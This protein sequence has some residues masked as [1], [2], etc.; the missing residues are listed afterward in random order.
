MAN[1]SFQILHRQLHV[2]RSSFACALLTLLALTLASA[3]R[4]EAACSNEAIREAQTSEVLPNGTTYLPSCMALE[5]LNPPKK[6]GQETS[7][8]GAFSADGSRALFVS[9]AALAETPGLQVFVGDNYVATRDPAGWATDPTSPPAPAAILWG[10]GLNGGPFAFGEDLDRWVMQGATQA[11][12]LAGESQFFT[13]APGGVFKALSP[14]LVPVDQSGESQQFSLNENRSSGSSAD[15]SAT[16]FNSKWSSTTYLSGDPSTTSIS[17]EGGYTPSYLVHRDALGQPSI[18]LLARDKDGVVY[19]GRCGSRLGGGSGLVAGAISPDASRIYFSTRPAQAFDSN[20]AEGPPCTTTNPL[21]ILKRS[22]TPSG[23]EITEL[24]PG[25]PS[26]AGDDIFQGASLDGTKAYLTSPRKLSADDLDTSADPCS[27]SLGSSKGCDLYLYDSAKA[28]GEQITLVSKGGAGDLEPGKD[29]NVLSSITAISADGSH[30]YFVAQGVLTSDQNPAG[31]SAA[32]GQPNLYLHNAQSGDLS[33]IGRLATTD[34]NTLWGSGNSFVQAYPVPLLGGGAEGGGDGHILLFLSNA[35]LTS[36]DADNGRADVYRYDSEVETLI[37][38]S[39]APGGPD[40]RPFA[41]SVDPIRATP[42]PNFA[43]KGRWASEDG[44]TVAFGTAEPLVDGD[45]DGDENPYLWHEGEL[46][47]LPSEVKIFQQLPILSPDGTEVG[48]TTT[49]RLLPQDGDGARDAYLARAGG[50]FANPAPTLPCDPLTEGACQGASSQ[51]PASPPAS[52]D[53]FSGP[54][55]LKQTPTCDKSFT[56]KH[57][58]C[59]KKSKKQK[60]SKKSHKRAG[61]KRGGSK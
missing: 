61:H 4:A 25:A 53:S 32:A 34:D 35:S 33:F 56:R 1:T 57:G 6:F 60:K 29:A 5:M 46:S 30:A 42:T 10:G 20:T 13:G 36:E 45:E 21:R 16:V 48:F 26:E 7:E 55:N 24:I 14:F 40:A 43:E 19:G 39:C 28:P 51:R 50:G 58:R 54:P 59:V 49:S 12:S 11:Q 52:T 37:C 3:S 27:S 41:A 2:G 8:V 17:E 38:V 47:R 9:K 44:Q 18:E 31:Q 23:P 22:E 15:L